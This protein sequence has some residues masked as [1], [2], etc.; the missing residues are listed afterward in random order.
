MLTKLLKQQIDTYGSEMIQGAFQGVSEE[1]SEAPGA[2]A[3]GRRLAGSRAAWLLLALMLIIFGVRAALQYRPLSYLVGDCPYYAMASVSMLYD[4]DLDLRNQLKGGL[5]VHGR[6]IALG[7]DGAWYPKHPLLMPLVSIPFLMAFGVP[8]F[9]IFNILVLALL[10]LAL[11][12]LARTAAPP[13]TA[14]AAA[15]LLITGSFLRRFDYNYSPDLF[16]TLVLVLAILLIIRGRDVAGGLLA[17]AAVAAKMTHLFLVPIFLGYAL[18]ARGWRGGLRA[19]CGAAGPLLALALLNLS[20]FGSPLTTSYDRNVVLEGDTVSTLSHRGLFDGDPIKGLLAEL[21]DL[22]HGLLTTAP[23]LFLA[24]P[25]LVLLFRRRP[26]EAVL[27]VV[28]GE[29]L[30]LL[31]ATYRHWDTSHYGNRFLMPVIAV[32]APAV[33]LTLDWIAS[34]LRNRDATLPEAPAVPAP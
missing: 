3:S 33:A 12:Q 10:A 30:L 5:A 15:F 2:S 4:G 21:F 29:F 34:R 24:L 20:L 27:Y 13:F 31:F 28:V 9:L 6:Q 19:C 14:A 8:G 23:V 26:R 17:G 16:A 22:Q 32:S 11:M 1:H 7:E 18:W 25:G